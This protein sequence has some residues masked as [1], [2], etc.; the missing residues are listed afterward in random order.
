MPAGGANESG[1]SRRRGV[2]TR[3]GAPS[4]GQHWWQ[5]GSARS[6]AGAAGGNDTAAASSDDSSSQRDRADEVAEA[7]EA[8]HASEQGLRAGAERESD[9]QLADA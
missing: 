9:G 3:N 5:V 6:T 1:Q 2:G 8:A 7:A 4:D